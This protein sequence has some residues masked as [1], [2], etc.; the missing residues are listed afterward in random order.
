M[1]KGKDPVGRSGFALPAA[2]LAMV[3]IGAIVTGGFYAAA[4]Q[5]LISDSVAGSQAAFYA[6]EQGIDDVVGSWFL[7]DYPATVGETKIVTGD[8]AGGAGVV[9][10][11]SVVVRKLADGMWLITSIGWPL[12]RGYRVAAARRTL[13]RVVRT[14]TLNVPIGSPLYV[15][16]GLNVKGNSFINGQDVDAGACNDDGDANVPGVVTSDTTQ[17]TGATYDPSKQTGIN[18][19]PALSQDTTLGDGKLLNYGDKSYD[20]LAAMGLQMSDANPPGTAPVVSGGDCDTSSLYNW[21]DPENA[22]QPCSSY[23]PIIHSTATELRLQGGVGQ[24]ILLVDG[25][26]KA[27][28]DFVFYG[29]IV[30]KGKLDMSG[31][32]NHFNGVVL[33]NSDSADISTSS[34]SGNS[35]IQYSSCAAEHALDSWIRAVPLASR[36]WFDFTAAGVAN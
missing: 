1:P 10:R 19:D 5:D 31:T 13:A 20:D 14:E 2:L 25:N 33:V 4:Q 29:I 23:F 28:G 35:V 15:L 30:V 6:A 24:G 34:T 17:V 21:G 7:A 26:L 3:V 11:D 9:G 18:G 8:V 27:T 16:G 12:N 36:S 32:G 22:G